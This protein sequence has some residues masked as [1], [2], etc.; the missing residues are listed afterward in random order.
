MVGR[1]I[2]LCIIFDPSSG[3]LSEIPVNKNQ[4]SVSVQDL[5]TILSSQKINQGDIQNAINS[6]NPS[7]A[8]A[9]T[10]AAE[11]QNTLAKFFSQ[12]ENS[13]SG[14]ITGTTQAQATLQATA[15]L[16]PTEPV[17]PAFLT[18][19]YNLKH[20]TGQQTGGNY[21]SSQSDNYMRMISGLDGSNVSSRGGYQMPGNISSSQVASLPSGMYGTRPNFMPI[22]ILVLVI[23]R[24][25][26][27]TCF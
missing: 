6:L 17:P 23:Y 27:F 9:T 25:C 26:R 12:L 10:I 22:P 15:N 2:R 4:T 16:A 7:T 5:K 11:E 8:P 1:K 20:G 18:K 24:K 3:T 19:L 21:S 13:F 14:L